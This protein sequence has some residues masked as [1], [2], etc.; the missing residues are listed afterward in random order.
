MNKEQKAYSTVLALG[1]CASLLC[2]RFDGK[3]Y[4]GLLFLAP[5][6]AVFLQKN[7]DRV[8]GVLYF[9]LGVFFIFFC[10][11]MP[12]IWFWHLGI[13]AILLFFS[14]EEKTQHQVLR[15]ALV[16]CYF[17]GGFNK[18]NP[19]FVAIEFPSIFPFS[20]EQPFWAYSAAAFEISIGI[21]L[22]HSKSIRYAF[23][24]SVFFHVVVIFYLVK[25]SWNSV[26][27]PW[28]ITLPVLIY[29]LKKD[30]V[31]EAFS[32][33]IAKKL[34]QKITVVLS[35]FIFC[36][37][38]SFRYISSEFYPYSFNMYAGDE[39]EL[40]FFFHEKDI[41]TLIPKDLQSKVLYSAEIPNRCLIRYE[42]WSMY[43][44]NVPPFNSEKRMEDL[45]AAF[46]QQAQSK[47]IV[48]DSCGYE[49][50]TVNHW[51]QDEPWVKSYP[52]LS[53]T[54]FFNHQ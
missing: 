8:L 20:A 3:E 30:N 12:Q 51:K 50:L 7:V 34:S 13:T 46:Y 19:W 53:K 4:I 31:S 17:W 9:L 6:L 29:F 41:S 40:T 2:C 37:V 1:L 11:E 45:G 44:Y 26:V 14:N 36:V 21:L 15:F 38:P 10:P 28:N 5:L 33:N 48:P 47:A 16:G 22:L 43:A 35:F 52:K 32:T 54:P 23:W 25:N 18:I 39:A 27:L 24:M 49:I 42:T